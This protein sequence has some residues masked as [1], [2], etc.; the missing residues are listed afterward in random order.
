[1]S[2]TNEAR[3]KMAF[4]DSTEKTFV[5]PEIETSALQYVKPRIQAIN[6]GTATNVEDLR[7]TFVSN[8]GASFV[9]ISGAQIIQT[10]EEV[11][12]SD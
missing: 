11:V 5:L 10:T 9:S 12:Y 4:D 6:N 3:I 1:M 8:G 2:S 7:Q